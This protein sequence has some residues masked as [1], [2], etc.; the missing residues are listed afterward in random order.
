MRGYDVRE[1]SSNSLRGQIGAVFQDPLLIAGTIRENIRMGKLDATNDEIESAARDAQIH[2]A[3]IAMPEGYETPIGEAGGRL[4]GGQRQR[5][6]IARA[7]IRRPS[8]LV[9]D[10]ATSALDPA[11]ESAIQ[12]TIANLSLGRTVISVTHRLA[13]ATKADKI[14]VFDGGRLVGQGTHLSLKESGGIY[15]ELWRKQSGVEVDAQGTAARIEPEWLRAIPLFANASES[16]L[17]R[18]A[19]ELEFER[20]DQGRTVFEEGDEG[21]KFYILARG[22]VDVVTGE[23]R[24]LAVLTDGDFFGEI[25]LIE[26][27]PRNATIRTLAPCSFLTLTHSRFDKLLDEEE[28]LRAAIRKIVDARLESR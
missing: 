18:V 8:V 20:L 7:L 27:V 16:V 2:D 1:L 4:S 6:A 3:I 9:L 12:E 25:A 23:G 17:E 14:F 5:L 28:D 13:W 10:E 15:A 26:N 21:D 22:K 11:S 24:R 19:G